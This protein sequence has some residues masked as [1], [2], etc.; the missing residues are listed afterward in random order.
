MENKNILIVSLMAT[1]KK[2]KQ[3]LLER[4]PLA[5]F[6]FIIFAIYE[7]ASTG[8]ISGSQPRV[9]VPLGVREQ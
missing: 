9:L 4:N 7:I 5:T 1:K 8:F 6:I 3:D 2:K